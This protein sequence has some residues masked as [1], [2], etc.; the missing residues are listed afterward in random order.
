M[1]K[2]YVIKPGT[3]LPQIPASFTLG[4]GETLDM[5]IVVMPGVSCELPLSVEL[6]GEG[7]QANLYGVYVCGAEEKVNIS[8]NLNH[9]VG[10]CN[11]NQLFKGIAGGKSHVGFDGRIIVAQDAQKTEA[12][13]SNH[14]IL[15]SDDARVDTRPQLEIY[16]DDVKCS[17]GATVGRLNEEEQFYMRSR[18]I[19]L[20][21]ARTLQMIS[22]VHPALQGIEDEE[23][24]ESLAAEIEDAIRSIL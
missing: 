6:V 22:F 20:K 13:Q 4:A 15:L 8:V 17:H 23:L 19:T 11:S 18:G 9:K 10:H 7:A 12:Y 5:T 2:L 3:E 14:N 21:E 1:H 24:R 16:A